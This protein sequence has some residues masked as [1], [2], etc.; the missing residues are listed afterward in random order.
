[1]HPSIEKRVVKE[2]AKL[3]QKEMIKFGLFVDIKEIE[4]K[5]KE[6]ILKIGKN[7]LEYHKQEEL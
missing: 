5:S 2:S 4:N 7:Y 1:M 6:F 3:L